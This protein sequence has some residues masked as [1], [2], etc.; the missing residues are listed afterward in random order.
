MFTMKILFWIAFSLLFYTYL[1][2]GL[3]SFLGARSKKKKRQATIQDQIIDWPEVTILVAAYNEASCIEAKIQN[4]LELDYP[5]HKIKYLFVTDGSTDQTP[6]LIRQFPDIRV[7]HSLERKGKIAAV[8]RAMEF[9]KTPITIFSDANAMLNSS[10]A[11]EIALQFLDPNVGAVAGEKRVESG[12]NASSGGESL[13]WKYESQLKKWDADWGS[14]VGAA[15]ELFAIRTEL[16]ENLA[17]DT[18][19]DDFMQT[20][21]IVK[22]G[23]RVAYAPKAFALEAG[24]LN[25]KEEMKRKIRISAGGFQSIL[26]LGNLVNPFE[27]GIVAIQY[28]SHRV[29]RWTVA[30]VALLLMFFSNLILINKGFV[31]Y[32]LLFGGQILFYGLALW[33]ALSTA[34]KSRI[35]G[36][37]VPCYFTMMHWCA[38]LGAWRF[39]RNTQAVTWE[40]A[41]RA[42]FK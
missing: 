14:V 16:F 10:A 38:W 11:K 4:S 12:Q 21:L 15:G 26:R 36:F 32:D 17:T 33:G 2:Y 34:G 8:E 25:L 24:S 37:F 29:F 23:Y 20:L 40:K 22:K 5:K 35:P 27:Y 1:G 30:P 19:L 39:F 31:V 41:R 3:I 6:A 18:L 13:Y 9:V 7:L 42:E 28:L